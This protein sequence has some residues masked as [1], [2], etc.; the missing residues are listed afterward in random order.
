MSI[1]YSTFNV[2]VLSI[3]VLKTPEKSTDIGLRK[4]APA[5]PIE[6][7]LFVFSSLSRDKKVYRPE[8]C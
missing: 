6:T 8:R 3:F 5:S 4:Q 2:F 7:F 1:A